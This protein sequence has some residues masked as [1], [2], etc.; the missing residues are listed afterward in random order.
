MMAVSIYFATDTKPETTK[1]H[2]WQ[3]GGITNVFTAEQCDQLASVMHIKRIPAGS[4]LFW[5]GDES[6]AV[7]WVLEGRMKLRK[8][9]SDGKDLLLSIVQSGDM[10]ADIDAWDTFHRYSAEAMGDVL[11]GV[12][13]RLQLEMLLCRNGEF[14]Y[15]FA[16]WMSQI[17]RQTES[18]LRDLLMGGKNGALASTLI[19][20]CNSFGIQQEDGLLIN[21]KLTN[22]ELAE[23]VGT[24]RE[25]I[26]RMLAKMKRDGIVECV[27]TGMLR[28]LDLQEL[29][30]MAGCPDC[31][32]C[33]NHICRI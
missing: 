29:R 28:I 2:L 7:Y 26:N 18:K 1:E 12:I 27:G 20:L 3:N 15:R 11:V 33:P 32:M 10:I 23:L 13:S 16:M 4:Y 21:I 14:A 30:H 17:Q 6:T 19:R 5:E 22:N 9:T 25:G 31:P 24:T 8:S